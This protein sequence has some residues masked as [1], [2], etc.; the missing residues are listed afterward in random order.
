MRT[1]MRSCTRCVRVC[2]GMRSC[3]LGALH[4]D[5]L[6]GRALMRR[7]S[8]RHLPAHRCNPYTARAPPHRTTPLALPPAQGPNC[9]A[10]YP[11]PRTGKVVS[12][13][14]HKA[15]MAKQEAAAAERAK[16]DDHGH[17]HG[18]GHKGGY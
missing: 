17:G 2:G 9:V 8:S 16:H 3:L 1:P 6:A 18:H 4:A 10:G 15:A 14:E 13:E 12:M 11:D 7:V 5:G